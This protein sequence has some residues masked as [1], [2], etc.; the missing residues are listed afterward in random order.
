MTAKS[1]KFRKKFIYPIQAYFYNRRFMRELIKEIRTNIKND[2]IK[3][4]KNMVE[5]WGVVRKMPKP[6]LTIFDVENKIKKYLEKRGFIIKIIQS[7]Q[8]TPYY[9]MYDFVW[10]ISL[11]D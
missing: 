6:P 3:D 1:I 5:W 11:P 2:L 7:V 8:K 4:N 9:S 10:E